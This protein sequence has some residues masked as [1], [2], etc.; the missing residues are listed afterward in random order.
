MARDPKSQEFTD[1]ETARRRD[2]VIKHM[3]STPPKLHKEMKIGKRKAK[4]GA[5]ERPASKGRVHKGKTRA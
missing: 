2:A 3:L 4:A 5:K 1:E